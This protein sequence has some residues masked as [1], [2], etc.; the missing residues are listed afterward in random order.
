[1][2]SSE[3]AHLLAGDLEENDGS[4]GIRRRTLR[5]SSQRRSS[6]S[7]A[8]NAS[9]ADEYLLVMMRM[10]TQLRL[11]LC[12]IAAVALLLA[13]FTFFVF[14]REL[15][16]DAENASLEHFNVVESPCVLDF[17]NFTWPL[18]A[19][20][21]FTAC[22]PQVTGSLDLTVR[23]INDNW[24]TVVVHRYYADIMFANLTLGS[25]ERTEP[26][27]IVHGTANF[28][29]LVAISSD[30][31]D[32]NYTAFSLGLLQALKLVGKGHF[33]FTLVGRVDAS[34]LGVSFN[35]SVSIPLQLTNSTNVDPLGGDVQ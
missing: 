4:S 11:Q 21:N 18:P 26:L 29:Q 24:V 34:V 31:F 27:T 14:P 20:F 32:R 7:L 16:V 15:G 9:P 22:L 1:M 17:S 33:S 35:T 8:L 3:A 5:S 2:S 25:F 30:K 10:R 19:T 12:L 28:R 6:T 13:V 23:M